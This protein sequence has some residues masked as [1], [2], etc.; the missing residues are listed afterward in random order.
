MKPLFIISCPIDTYSGYGARS[1]DLV[2]AIVKLNRYNVQVLPQR[3]G[4]TPWGF[5]EDH[6]QEWGFLSTLLLPQGNQLPA[7][8]K[9][10]AQVTVPNEFQPVGDFNIGFTAGIE[11]TICAP[12]WIEGLNRMDLNIVSSNHAKTVFENSKFNQQDQQGNTIG[13]VSLNKPV[14]VLF[15]GG[16]LAKYFPTKQKSSI[17]LDSVKETFA[18][19]F[20]GHW[21]QGNIGEDRKNVGL[22]LKIFY[23][24]F[25]NQKK[26]PALILK[27]SGGGASYLDRESIL[28]KIDNIRNT[29]EA[30]TLPNVYLLHG[31]FTD[32]EINDIYNHK[33]VKA[34]VSLT[35]GEGF[36][37]PLL[38]FSLTKKPV[39]TTNWSG[40]TDFL[41]PKFTILVNGNLSNVHDSAVVKD[42]I[43]KESQWFNVNTSDV[44]FYL[45]DIFDSYPKYEKKA[46]LQYHKSKNHFNYNKMVETLG[47]LIDNYVPQF[48]SFTNL[49]LP[50][51]K[52]PKLK[53][54]ENV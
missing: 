44:V 10:W 45:K 51:L 46:L 14:E 43:I 33:K 22:M 41:D 27:T 29:I 5:I 24:T 53:T 7:K 18:Y 3:W 2:K 1:R 39:I 50:E 25:K 48:P 19:L 52:L 6:K 34:M 12:Q 13:E 47:E 11:T 23:E 36:G 54:I 20:V 4:N 38:E 28:E 16:D 17:D 15:E 9:I 26:A 30:D 40:H 49:K 35:K 21:M 32:K 37:R 42:I 31:E 8:P